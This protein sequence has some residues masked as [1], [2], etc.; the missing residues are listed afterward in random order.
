MIVT[1]QWAGLVED[2]VA[3]QQERDV[4]GSRELSRK[5]LRSFGQ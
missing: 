2:C 4:A 1:T 5:D 3:G